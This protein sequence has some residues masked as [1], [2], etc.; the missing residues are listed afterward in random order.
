M[1]PKAYVFI[2]TRVGESSGVASTLRGLR[3]V[4]MVDCVTG[5]FDV[6]ALIRVPDISA[7]GDLVG[8]R[9]SV[10]SGVTRTITCFSLSAA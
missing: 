1:T 7:V 9:I 8:K 2:E 6:V 3:G 5:P 10:I 4:E